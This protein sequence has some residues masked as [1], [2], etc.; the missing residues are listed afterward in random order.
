MVPLVLLALMLSSVAG[1]AWYINSK[2]DTLDE[3]ST[4]PPEV[5]VSETGDGGNDVVVDT[6]AAREHVAAVVAST[7]VSSELPDRWV[8][9]LVMGVD[10]R[11]GEPIDVEVRADSLSV[12]VLDRDDGSCRMLSIPRDTRFEMPGYGY[13]KMN[14]A[15]AV[16]GV[17]Y[18][19]LMVE[20]LLGIKIDHYGLIDFSGVEQLVDAIGRVVVVNE[21]EFWYDGISY[22]KGTLALDGHEALIYARYRE[23]PD[24]EYGRQVRQQQVARALLSRAADLD[25]V[26]AIPDLLNTVEG[27][28][29][30]DLGLTEMIDLGQEFRN[31]CTAD[32]LET[33]LLDG[34]IHDAYDEIMEQDLSFV[35]LTEEEIEKK[36]AWLLS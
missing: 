6:T 19:Q 24:G 18:Q 33:A 8:S 13:T 29:R 22:A 21:Y 11:P 26:T 9:I 3:I 27:H 32:T 4:P 23:G 5:S 25:V 28:V 12:V 30:T 35:L 15:L 36:V 7:P 20:D 2:F 16:G 31:S 17:P 1:G 10:S 14:S 34:E